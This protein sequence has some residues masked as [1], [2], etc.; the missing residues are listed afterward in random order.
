[1]CFHGSSAFD[2]AISMGMIDL[3]QHPLG[4]I[5]LVQGCLVQEDGKM[6]DIYA[7]STRYRSVIVS[8]VLGKIEWDLDK[9]NGGV[10]ESSRMILEDRFAESRSM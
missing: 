2:L 6:V 8:M 3:V 5:Y 10:I 1:M 9:I 4:T 7:A